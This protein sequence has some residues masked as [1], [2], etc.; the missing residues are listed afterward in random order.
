MT[1]NYR[2]S[3][4]DCLVIGG[5]E[6]RLI[7]ADASGSNWA[8]LDQDEVRL[9]FTG[10]EFLQLL[11]QP[12]TRLKRGH[13]SDQAA[14]RRLRCDLRYLQTVPTPK[15][16]KALWQETCA[17]FFI[18]AEAA[19]ETRRS[20]A[21]VE[22]I[23]PI[24]EGRV[25]AVEE[26]GQDV[27]RTPRAGHI[28]TR[29]RFPS[30]RSLLQWVRNYEAAGRTPL[31][32]LRKRRMSGATRKLL[33]EV[34]GLLAARVTEFLDRNQPSQ[35]EIVRRVN[36]CFAEVNAA[37]EAIGMPRLQVPSARTVRRRIKALDPFEVV[38]QRKGIEAARR[39]FGFYEEGLSA[40]YP[41]QRVEMDEWRVD[42]ATLLGESGALDGLPPEQRARFEVGRRWIYVVMDCAT[43]CI[44]AILIVATPNAE[45]A[46]RAL[47]LVTVDRTPIAEAAGC[48]SSWS[49]AGGIGILVTDQG[50]AFA[51]ED[52]RTAVI[53]LGSTYEAPPAG[54]PKLRHRIERVLRTFGLQLAP[55]LIG[56]TF[57][58]SVERGDYPSE[59]WA[60][61]TDDELAQIFTLFIVDI[62]HN[63]P[64][65]GLNGETPANA[66]KRL[67]NE[68]GVTPP[69]D[70]NTR[71]VVFGL[72]HTRKLDR[73]GLR[74]AGINYTCPAL[75]EAM[76]RGLA[77]EVQL[78]VDP[79]DLT[80]ISVCLG[81]EWIVA[82]AVPRAVWGLSL[83]EWRA[84]VSDFRTRFKAEAVL[85]EDIIREAR[86]KIRAIDARAR[87]LRR[88][89]PMQLSKDA[90][91]RAEDQLFLGLRIGPEG[92]AATGDLQQPSGRRLPD[93]DDLLGDVIEPD[94]PVSEPVPVAA[95]ALGNPPR[96]WSFDD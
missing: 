7:R 90:L 71:R 2:V 9:S 52:F 50:S 86:R 78:R 24:L 32:F 33:S 35:K 92:S 53:D 38:A 75:Q 82:D 81:H 3:E 34:E 25:N 48:Q 8:R 64:H 26:S 77:G 74:V 68:Q 23:L 84:I 29:R 73:H 10:D 36:D 79:E 91:E 5:S 80:H 19:G 66:W 62:Y 13:F 85:T 93:A 76:L 41:L 15:R 83:D 51:S 57:S 42:V 95:P 47:Q 40:D 22:N 17:K 44:L 16:A 46:I 87:Q 72:P 31:V 49:Q 20:S 65:S 54:V 88:I 58:N 37:R 94:T 45:D 60:A 56:R 1:N 63:T 27:G 96:E 67:S 43:R 6:H 30:S 89:Q 14:F 4:A 69:P 28:F 18:E 21:S 59:E 55:M 61:L 12:D 70:A 39:K 11:A